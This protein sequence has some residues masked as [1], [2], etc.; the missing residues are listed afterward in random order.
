MT[1]I[2][3]TEGRHVEVVIVV[4]DAQ[5]STNSAAVVT[6]SAMDVRAYTSLAYTIAVATNTVTWWVYGANASDYSDEVIVDG[7]TNVTAGS[8]DSYAV[9]QAPYGYYRV[10][11][12]ST[13]PD[14][15]GSATVRGIAKP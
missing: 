9:T 6:G 11:I 13:T 5:T 2:V 12:Q 1:N 4:P 10:K 15:H 14:S 3:T 8:V 7:P